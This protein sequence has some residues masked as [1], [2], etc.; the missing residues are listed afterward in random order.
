MGFRVVVALWVLL[1][2]FGCNREITQTV[3]DGVGQGDTAV[4]LDTAPIV[5][6][7]VDD[8]GKAADTADT[9]QTA[10][11]ADT[12]QTTDTAD[13]AQSDQSGTEDQSTPG[14][15]QVQTALLVNA[16]PDQLA[17]SGTTISLAVQI[18]GGTAPY[19]CQW[20]AGSTKVAD[21]CQTTLSA[22]SSGTLTVKVADGA[23]NTGEDSISLT[24]RQ[25]LSVDASQDLT[26]V[27]GESALLS[28]S[29]VGGSTPV[30]CS[31][32]ADGASV[33]SSCT[34]LSVS[35]TK[36]TTYAITVSD[37]TGATAIDLVTVTVLP[38]LS[39]KSADQGV[40]RGNSVTLVAEVFGGVGP[41]SCVWKAG[42]VEVS[43]GC[44]GASVTPQT[45]TEYTV[46][47]TDKDG[48]T[49]SATLTV[50]VYDP[51][52][53]TSVKANIDIISGESAPL[54]VTVSGGAPAV[55][56]SWTVA[57]SEISTDCSG[58]TVSPTSNTLYTFVAVDA[59][60]TIVVT[61][62]GVNVWDPLQLSLAPTLTQ[63][64]VGDSLILKRTLSG[65]VP[66][67]SCAWTTPAGTVSSDCDSLEV[68]PSESTIYTL[69]V[70]DKNS[71]KLSAQSEIRVL[72][73][74]TIPE[75]SPVIETTSVTLTAEATGLIGAASCVW[76]L[77][78]ATLGT[79]CTLEY[80]PTATATLEVTITDDST[81]KSV[82]TSVKVTLKPAACDDKVQNGTET[83]VDCGGKPVTIWFNELTR[84]T[85]T[86]PPLT[87]SFAFAEVVAPSG[88]DLMTLTPVP[89]QL[90]TDKASYQAA[91]PS[92]LIPTPPTCQ[93]ETD[94]G[95]VQTGAC[96]V[97]TDLP[98]D[99]LALFDAAGT[100]ID[101]VTFDPT[102]PL[103]P[104]VGGLANGMIPR[105][106][107]LVPL[108][109]VAPG[110]SSA[111]PDESLCLTGSGTKPSDFSWT[112]GCTP[113]VGGTVL[114]LGKG[115]NPGQT[116][117]GFDP[118]CPR[119]QEDD[120]CL[121]DD[122]CDSGLTCANELCTPI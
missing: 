46:L 69:S 14:P 76:K 117:T 94:S 103:V 88:V 22:D 92:L 3:T 45:T 109:Q 44:D 70:T 20:F 35:P 99:A 17:T 23:G 78:A 7:Q 18:S 89:Y 27:S 19:S 33:G 49:A 77:G 2:A 102:L 13:L 43:G 26:I 25:S 60:G 96:L 28:G 104:A 121:I 29:V 111:L 105:P 79:D 63:I 41:I 115:L 107:G 101:F 47:A 74:K 16:G 112:T 120:A 85:T 100:L 106:V 80:T 8:G 5:D 90:T 82:S 62:I 65:G 118:G 31:W 64:L 6:T 93:G 119:C 59:L 72:K 57:G 113:T 34:N 51:L 68:A 12:A 71:N 73:A 24:V 122:D 67:L 108:K 15:D 55:T 83:D 39:V 38:A 40:I 52:T 1:L 11:T 58:L 9:A 56:C 110:G 30:S 4:A 61:A 95:G 84:L 86:Q 37:A 50:T 32:L 87:L 116:L 53:V 36:T 10:D 54:G 114:G 42:E 81:N 66:T 91:P 21:G 98:I 97:V 75:P 48:R